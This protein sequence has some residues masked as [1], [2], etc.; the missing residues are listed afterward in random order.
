MIKV[1]IFLYVVMSYF[2]LDHR[3]GKS[4]MAKH[5]RRSSI[6]ILRFGFLFPLVVFPKRQHMERTWMNE[7]W[8]DLASVIN[9]YRS[10]ACRHTSRTPTLLNHCVD[11]SETLH[12]YFPNYLPYFF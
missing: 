12:K 4:S 9:S 7:A 10:Q 1:G 2:N 6:I 5:K 8:K 3:K 11:T